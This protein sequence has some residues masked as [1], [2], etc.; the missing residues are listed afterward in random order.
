MTHPPPAEFVDAL[1]N[2]KASQGST[3]NGLKNREALAKKTLELYE[4]AGE[5][6]MRDIAKRALYLKKEIESTRGEIEKLER[7]E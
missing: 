5:R 3:E 4:K 6:A 2:Y 1:R 7:E